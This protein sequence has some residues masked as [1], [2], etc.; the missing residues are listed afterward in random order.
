MAFD[1]KQLVDS[2]YENILSQWWEDWGWESPQKDFLPEDATG[3]LM[4]LDGDVPVCAGFIYTT[5]SAVA[6]VDWI[7]SNKEYR[8]KP[9]RTEAI[10]LLIE[11][12]TNVC[13]KNGAKYVYALIKHKSL[14]ETYE[15]LGY[16]AGDSY[17]KEM[18]KL[19]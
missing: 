15:K 2:D 18:I 4:I 14:I 11:T 17:N 16:I 19:L 5:N 7:I 1:I 3:G 8:K 6:W 12:L 10:G 9:Q 13:K